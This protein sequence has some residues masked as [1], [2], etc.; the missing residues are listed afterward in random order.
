MRL[1]SHEN[2]IYKIWDIKDENGRALVKVSSSRPAKENSSY[3]QFQLSNGI[4]KNGYLPSYFLDVRF[5]G[6]AYNKLKEM[7]IGDAITNVEMELRS[8][9]YWDSKEQCRKYPKYW[10]LTIFS[11]EKYDFNN[12]EQAYAKNLDKA[13]AV[14][15]TPVQ[16]VTQV[17]QATYE[18][19]VQPVTPVAPVQQTAVARTA[20]DECPF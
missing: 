15:E 6:H 16:S 17:T 19:P 7:Q 12:R 13:P 2:D 1:R 14:A 5:V 20:E 18:Q 10:Q 9:A 3:D 11:F 4:G 8:E